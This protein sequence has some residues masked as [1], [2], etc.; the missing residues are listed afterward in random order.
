MG[1]PILVFN[2]QITKGVKLLGRPSWHVVIGDP[3]L[4]S[5]TPGKLRVD[6]QANEPC[7]L[8]KMIL[9]VLFHLF[10]ILKTILQ[11]GCWYF[12]N[13]VKVRLFC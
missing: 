4:L 12:I 7:S 6:E 3:Q 10:N 13:L 2:S 5:V 11:V 8:K 1:Q 9:F